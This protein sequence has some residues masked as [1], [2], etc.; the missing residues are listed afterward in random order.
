[1][2]L[3]R[4]S[5]KWENNIWR[6]RVVDPDKSDAFLRLI[7]DCEEAMQTHE[8]YGVKTKHFKARNPESKVVEGDF[9]I[10]QRL[11]KLWPGNV[12]F[13]ERDDKSDAE[14]KFLEA[15]KHDRAH[16]GEKWLSLEDF[17]NKLSSQLEEFN[18]EPRG[19]R[20]A[21]RSPNEIWAEHTNEQPLRRLEEEDRWMISTHV[22]EKHIGPQ[23][24]KI[25]IHGFADGN[26]ALLPGQSVTVFCHH[27]CPSLVHVRHP[28]TGKLFPV[29]EN[30][31][32]AH[33][34]TEDEKTQAQETGR[35][36]RDFNRVG[37]V[38]ADS[39]R[40]PI[41]NIVTNTRPSG[42]PGEEFGSQ[43][44]RE[45]KEH[46]E[47]TRR[48]TNARSVQKSQARGAL[49]AALRDLDSQEKAT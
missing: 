45:K 48:N 7:R 1:V 16:P 36:I 30:V 13:R 40:H 22:I 37:K 8:R 19:G 35:R 28:K 3:P 49:V 20:L 26:L 34:R 46:V 24:F 18:A 31:M 21:G 15:V 33:P 29:K 41:I 23:G 11:H 5:Y 42:P 9:L 44:E 12:G 43:M 10:H 17:R 38:L 32:V 6:A 47:Q 39:I 27:D 4:D 14:K 2:G 25:G